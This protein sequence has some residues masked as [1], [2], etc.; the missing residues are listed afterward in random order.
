MDLIGQV[1]TL[2]L[3]AVIAVIVLMW[4]RADDCRHMEEIARFTAAAERREELLHKAF[5]ENIR[6]T[7]EYRHAAEQLTQAIKS[8]NGR[9]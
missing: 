2:G 8:L 5:Q 9:Q 1:S 4:K 3:G 7:I 6:A